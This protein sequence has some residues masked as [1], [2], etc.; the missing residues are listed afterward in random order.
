MNSSEN[1]VVEWKEK[2]AKKKNVLSLKALRGQIQIKPFPSSDTLARGK[3]HQHQFEWIEGKKLRLEM[4]INLIHV[5]FE[6][7]QTRP[8]TID[9]R[10]EKGRRIKFIRKVYRPQKKKRKTF[11]ASSKRLWDFPLF[12]SDV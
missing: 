2:K 5:T 9:R 11:P 8:E 4:K 7:G 6:G 1:F 3:Q 10:A 12:S